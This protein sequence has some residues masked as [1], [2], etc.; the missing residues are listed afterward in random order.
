M[1]F[2]WVNISIFG[3]IA[4]GA[5]EKFRRLNKEDSALKGKG[6]AIIGTTLGMLSFLLF[7]IESIVK[8]F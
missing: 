2:T 8:N 5:G 1:M 3:L 7:I 6:I 4:I